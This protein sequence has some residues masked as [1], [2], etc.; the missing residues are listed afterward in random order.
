MLQNQTADQWLHPTPAL[1][2]E[3][4]VWYIPKS[5]TTDIPK[6]LQIYC[7]FIWKLLR[8]L[9]LNGNLSVLA[10]SAKQAQGYHHTQLWAAAVFMSEE[11]YTV[12]VHPSSHTAL[13]KMTSLI[14]KHHHSTHNY[15]LYT[16]CSKLPFLG[17]E[18]ETEKSQ[19]RHSTQLVAP[20]DNQHR[21]EG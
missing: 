4:G 19:F 18:G 6:Y 2:L 1:G 13:A 15:F 20:S 14:Q 16:Q 9:L 21:S 17:G 10:V 3:H 7:S 12:F 8:E 5:H 11:I